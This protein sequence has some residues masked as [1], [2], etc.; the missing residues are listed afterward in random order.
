VRVGVKQLI[1]RVGVLINRIAKVGIKRPNTSG[2][3]RKDELSNKCSKKE[4]LGWKSWPDQHNGRKEE[5]KVRG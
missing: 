2:V 5:S 1:C 4:T 3:N